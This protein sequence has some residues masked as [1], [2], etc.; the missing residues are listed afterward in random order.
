[1][2]YNI[3]LHKL[4]VGMKTVG[5]ICRLWNLSRYQ[6]EA[7][8][9]RRRLKYGGN[10]EIGEPVLLAPSLGETV[11]RIGT[12]LAIYRCLQILFSAYKDGPEANRLSADAWVTRKN[13]AY[14]F[15]GETAA[16]LMCTGRLDDL[17]AVR[18]Y[19]E[20]VVLH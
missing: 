13:D 5:R 3:D 12:I 7:L 19:L 14:L 8:L 18:N 10:R 17:L 20:S 16:S 1:M 9:G 6:C 11:V 15:R 4:E 2:S